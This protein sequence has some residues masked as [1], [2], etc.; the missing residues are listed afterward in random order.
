MEK[1]HRTAPPPAPVLSVIVCMY[2]EEDVVDLLVE[3]PP[4][5]RLFVVTRD[6]DLLVEDVTGPLA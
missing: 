1:P 3:V 2:N 5:T 6:A 4:A